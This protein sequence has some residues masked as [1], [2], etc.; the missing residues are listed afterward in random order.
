MIGLKI[1]HYFLC[2]STFLLIQSEETRT[3]FPAL[4]FRPVLPS[5]SIGSLDCLSLFLLAKVI[6]VV[7]LRPILITFENLTLFTCR[8]LEY[9]RDQLLEFKKQIDNKGG[10]GQGGEQGGGFGGGFGGFGGGGGNEV[11]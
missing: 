10:Q 6:A 4:F 8:R 1:P 3:R 11:S 5:N 2:Q 7:L 9:T